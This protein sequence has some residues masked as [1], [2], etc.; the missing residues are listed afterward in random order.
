MKTILKFILIIIIFFSLYF[1]KNIYDERKQGYSFYKGKYYHE[2]RLDNMLSGLIQYIIKK[3]KVNRRKWLEKEGYSKEDINKTFQILQVRYKE[4]REKIFKYCFIDFSEKKYYPLNPEFFKE[5]DYCSI[6]NDNL[7][8]SS[9]FIDLGVTYTFD[10]E[11]SAF[12]NEVPYIGRDWH[13]SR[14]EKVA[15]YQDINI[16]GIA[17]NYAYDTGDT[18]Y[19]GYGEGCRIYNIYEDK[20]YLDKPNI[21]ITF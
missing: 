19:K 17:C 10:S 6:S 3:D 1:V 13:H 14:K 4:E 20:I 2:E 5:M 12:F 7:A 18:E 9:N 11:S 8:H 16:T 21:D 15:P